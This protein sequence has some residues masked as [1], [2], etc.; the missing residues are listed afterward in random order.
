M[1]LAIAEGLLRFDHL[2]ADD[3]GAVFDLPA[4]GALPGGEVLAV[5]EDHRVG[6]GVAA[7][8][9]GGDDRGLLPLDAREVFLS[10]SGRRGERQQQGSEG[11]CTLQH[12][13]SSWIR[14]TT[15]A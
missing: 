2:L 14:W 3:H 10:E 13:D 4:L 11:G 6:G 7:L 15:V 8:G 5:E 9:P 12:D 1:E